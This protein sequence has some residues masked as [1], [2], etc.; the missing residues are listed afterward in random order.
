MNEPAQWLVDHVDL[1]PRGGVVLDVACGSGRNAVFLAERGWRV[2][3][4]DRTP[5]ALDHPN[6][7]VERRDL[8]APGVSFGTARY[9]AVIVF[10]YLHRPL[11]PAIV[12]AI[13]PGGVLIYETFT[14]GQAARG[15]P[16][17]PA[18]LLNDGEL[19]SLVAPLRVLRSREGEHAGRLVASIVAM[20]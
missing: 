13:A 5:G 2:H 4:V 14:I 10:N 16:R 20:R 11:M 6:I 12:N 19:A 17:N 15:R 9:N 7:T 3:A 1:I 8:E 18:F